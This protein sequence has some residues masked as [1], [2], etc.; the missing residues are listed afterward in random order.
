[1]A[2][3]EKKIVEELNE[4]IGEAQEAGHFFITV[5]YRVKET[6]HHFQATIDF[7]ADDCILSLNEC[8]KLV[9][10]A[11]PKTPINIA[12]FNPRTHK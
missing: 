10:K 1:M 12:R 9:R 5:S 11:N 8:E 6:L 4:K 7:K 3:D 2:R